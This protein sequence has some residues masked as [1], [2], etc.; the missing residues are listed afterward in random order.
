[1]KNICAFRLVDIKA[2]YLLWSEIEL[3]VHLILKHIFQPEFQWELFRE[4]EC[5][6]VNVLADRDNEY[7]LSVLRYAVI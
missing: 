2:L 3:L 4:L 6:V 5:A 1:M 7:T